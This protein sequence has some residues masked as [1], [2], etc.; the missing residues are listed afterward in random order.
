MAIFKNILKKVWET[1]ILFFYRVKM[2]L[3]SL[4]I[5]QLLPFKS[6]FSARDLCDPRKIRRPLV[7]NFPH[8]SSTSTLG[9]NTT[10]RTSSIVHLLMH[11]SPLYFNLFS[12]Y[13]TYTLSFIRDVLPRWSFEVNK[14]RGD[15]VTFLFSLLVVCF[16]DALITDDEPLFEPV[17][18]SL[19][20]S[21][22]MIIFGLAW[23]AENLISSRYGSYTGRDKRVWV[24]W[25]K[26]FWLIEGWYVLSFGAAAMFVITP[27]YN[28]LSYDVAMVVTWWNW[29]TRI[30]FFN[31]LSLY[32]IL[33]YLAYYLQL[34]LRHMGWKKSL[35]LVSLVNLGLGYLLYSQFLISFFCYFTD[36][37]WYHKSRL[38]DYVQLS[39]EPHKW[40]WGN[41]KRDHFSYHRSTTVFWFK[42]DNPFA[43]AMMF[44]NIFFF[45][46]LFWTYV[47]WVI[48]FRRIYSTKELTYTY[49]TYCVSSLRQ[50]MYY[51]LFFYIFILFSFVVAY[52][53]LPIETMWIFSSDSLVYAL[54]NVAYDYP[55]LL[56]SLVF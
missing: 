6:E 43:A 22:V 42:T 21:W 50:F 25:Y 9:G 52:W 3:F 56:Y 8:P 14:L 48:L 10:F 31:F 12:T 24:S 33:I 27:F 18:W 53:R 55:S 41:A 7:R 15:A 30:F 17:E 51:F 19:T 26:T 4:S 2:S 16:I 32:A 54:I 35:F 11:Y 44:F 47:Y 23:V 38:V 29:Y 5:N 34:N 46:C 40:A 37:N 28:E 20:Q 36:P 13:L 39:H 1:K 49:L 45:F